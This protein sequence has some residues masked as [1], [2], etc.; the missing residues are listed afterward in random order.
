MKTMN[1]ALTKD[2]SNVNSNSKEKFIH[3][4]DILIK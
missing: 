1:Q 2:E 3:N 4:K